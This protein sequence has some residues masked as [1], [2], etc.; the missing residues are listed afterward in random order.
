MAEAV[1]WLEAAGIASALRPRNDI[2]MVGVVPE[3]LLDSVDHN[4]LMLDC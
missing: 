4:L 3:G 1:S 2:C